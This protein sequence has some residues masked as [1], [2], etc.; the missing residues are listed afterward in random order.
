MITIGKLKAKVREKNMATPLVSVIIPCFNSEKY[1]D[2]AIESIL[3]QSYKNIEIIITD[4]ASTDMTYA[5]L[6]KFAQIDDRVNLIHHDSNKGL[7]YTL[8]EMIDIAS[9]DYI[10]RMDSDDVS[11]ENRINKQVCFMQNN[12][13]IDVCGSNALII[14]KNGKI[15]GKRILPTSNG[16]IRELISIINDMVHPSIMGKA[17]IFKENKY[18]PNYIHAEDYELWCRLLF[19]GK[20]LFAN[21]ADYLIK[22]RISEGQVSQKNIAVQ[23][24]V[25]ASVLA[26]YGLIEK[27]FAD[28]HK[29]IFFECKKINVFDKRTKEYLILMYNKIKSFSGV[30]ITIPMI[31]MLAFTKKNDYRL[32]IRLFFT[33][34]G[35][36]AIIRKF[37]GYL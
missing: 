32:F 18:D 17:G 33:R 6:E 14:D 12:P 19:E 35:M 28:I 7:V 11:D 3:Q 37:E 23:S 24:D 4:D 2:E 27:K 21:I 31:K 10:A 13:D 16:D 20:Y 9:G 29:S 22:Y 26:K 25:S 15:L 36:I 1:V 30:N 8:N 34:L 5:K